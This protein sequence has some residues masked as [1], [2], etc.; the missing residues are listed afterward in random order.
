MMWEGAYF[1]L[2]SNLVADNHAPQGS[3]LWIGN[4]SGTPGH[5]RLLHTTIAH[6]R[7]GGEGVYVAGY[8]TVAF[9]NTIIA[10]HTVVGV[11][12]TTDDVV[13]LE[14]TLWHANGAQTSGPVTIIGGSDVIGDP[15]FSSPL[16]WDYHLAAGSPAV[17]SGVEAGVDFDMDGDLRPSDGDRDDIA[18]EDIGADELVFRLVYLPQTLRQH[19]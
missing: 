19:Q 2:T 1:T 11:S 12:A 10:G 7:G 5:G 16:G 17:D 9:T 8:S 15:L 13:T 14:A 18:V 4:S 6:N 3:G